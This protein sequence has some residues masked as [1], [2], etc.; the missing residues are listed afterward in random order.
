MLGWWWTTSNIT[1]ACKDGR[2]FSI[3]AIWSPGDKLSTIISTEPIRL[4]KNHGQQ[5]KPWLN[6]I[7][8]YKQNIELY[9]YYKTHPYPLALIDSF[10]LSSSYLKRNIQ[11][12]LLPSES[13]NSCSICLGF[14]TLR[15]CSYYSNMLEHFFQVAHQLSLAWIHYCCGRDPDID[16]ITLF[17]SSLNLD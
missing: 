9:L 8:S 10:S 12:V 14:S 2:S 15:I 7:C 17:A 4:I 6:S 11:L 3:Q 13:R 16:R 1:H 5:K